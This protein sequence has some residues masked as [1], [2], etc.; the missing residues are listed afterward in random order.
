[1]RQNRGFT[2]IE[3]MITIAIIAILAAIALPSYSDYVRR[4]RLTE[5]LSTMSSQRVK[6]EQFFQDNRS[7]AGACAA[8]TVAP[9]P[10]TPSFTYACALSGAGVVP[11]TYTITATGTGTMLGFVYTMTEANVR[12]TTGLPAGWLGTGNACWVTKKDGSC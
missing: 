8:G 4:G 11:S 7:Y 9:L 3:L 6:M 2:L 5:G 10:T 1:M 12:T